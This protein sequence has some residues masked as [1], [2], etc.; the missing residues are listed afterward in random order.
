MCWYNS[1]H[2]LASFTI[3]FLVKSPVVWYFC[4]NL[5][6]VYVSQRPN[7]KRFLGFLEIEKKPSLEILV[8]DIANK[9]INTTVAIFVYFISQNEKFNL[10]LVNPSSKALR[11]KLNEGGRFFNGLYLIEKSLPVKLLP[12]QRVL[13]DRYYF[14]GLFEYSK[15]IRGNS[16]VH[17]FVCKF[18]SAILLLLLFVLCTRSYHFCR[19]EISSR[20]HRSDRG[21]VHGVSLFR[22]WS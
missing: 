2:H 16:F 4:G 20:F 11:Q 3:D 9:N 1:I 22:S 5:D 12:Y 18:I 6:D 7:K 10:K 15:G 13:F 8:H 14:G 19:N 17:S 21:P